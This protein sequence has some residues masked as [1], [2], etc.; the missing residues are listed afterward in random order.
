MGHL[1]TQRFPYKKGEEAKAYA[2]QAAWCQIIHDNNIAG[3][4]GYIH[5]YKPPPES[6]LHAQAFNLVR[7]EIEKGV[8]PFDLYFRIADQ[9]SSVSN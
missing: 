2:F 5:D 9:G 7:R 8:K 4:R 1:L 6:S 3:L